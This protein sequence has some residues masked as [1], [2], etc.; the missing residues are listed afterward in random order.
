MKTLK[1]MLNEAK[2][3]IIEMDWGFDGDTKEERQYIVD[4]ENEYG[5]YIHQRGPKGSRSVA[6]VVGTNKDLIKYL[7]SDFVGMTMSEIKSDYPELYS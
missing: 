1:E 3:A 7:A 2:N 5:V 4:M 6:D